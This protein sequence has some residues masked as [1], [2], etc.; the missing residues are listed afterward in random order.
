MDTISMMVDF[1]DKEPVGPEGS[2]FLTTQVAGQPQPQRLRSKE[3]RCF[4]LAPGCRVFFP[5]NGG[6]G[7][8]VCISSLYNPPIAVSIFLSRSPLSVSSSRDVGLATPESLA[9][10]GLGA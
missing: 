1:D 5:A 8:W 6:V 7:E 4:V 9:E 10:Q 2:T 3:L